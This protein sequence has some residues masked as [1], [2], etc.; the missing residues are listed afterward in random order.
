MNVQNIKDAMGTGA[1][2]RAE[3]LWMDAIE[4]NPAPEAIREV[5]EA[6]VEADRAETASMLG[7][8][9]LEAHEGTAAEKLLPM[10]AAALLAVPDSEELLGEVARLVKEVHGQAEHFDAVYESAGLESGQSPR[11]ALR[12]LETCL[13]LQPGDWLGGRFE[14][15]VARFQRVTPLGEMEIDE[16]GSTDSLDAKKLADDF[17]RLDADDFRVRIREADDAAEWVQKKPGEVLLGLAKSSGGQ[18][19]SDKLKD[20]LVPKYLDAKKWTSWWGRARTAAKKTAELTLEGRNPVTIAYHAGGLS[21]EDELAGELAEAYGPVDFFELLGRYLSEAAARNV[22]PDAE[23]LQEMSD[24]LSARVAQW[25]PKRPADALA[26]VTALV[27]GRQQ[28]LPEPGPGVPSV[29]EVLAAAN[30][31]ADAVAALPVAAFWAPALEAVGQ[32]DDAGDVLAALFVQSPAEQLDA[33]GEMLVACGRGEVIA[34]AVDQAIL[35]PT[36][37]LNVLVWAWGR[38]DLPAGE[39]PAAV[40]LLTKMLAALH[41]IDHKWQADRDAKRQARQAIRDALSTG[42]GESVRR[43]LE[44]MDQGMAAVIL[45]QINRTDGLAVSLREDIELM[46]RNTFPHLFIKKTIQP[47]EDESVIW[48]TDAGLAARQEELRVLKDEKMPANA[49]Q[50]GEAAEE[51]DLRENADWQAAI[52]ERDM[53]VSRVRKMSEELSKAKIIEPGS[54]PSDH[55]S[56]GSRVT[57]QGPDGRSVD[58]KFLGPWDSDTER[59]IYS[60]QTRL[61]EALLGKKPGESVEIELDGQAGTYTIESLGQAIE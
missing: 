45:N 4:D 29:A 8:A 16:D 37:R 30:A 28:G 31:P 17:E 41:D 15:R 46:L 23:F 5:L 52:E 7:W 48:T 19:D 39:R 55:V 6:F 42:G 25:H 54:A 51:G 53:L 2:D 58:V 9:L 47:W 34:E 11:R 50:I 32:R 35:D 40:T 33:L 38:E 13:A 56:V 26:A 24:T 44:Q 60:Y 61:A 1:W 18:T 49:K 57:L 22:E 12:T 20:L 59:G 27:A 3:S 43:A 14:P 10:A 21:L 36:S